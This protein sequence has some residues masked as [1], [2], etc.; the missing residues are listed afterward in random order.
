MK[1]VMKL[2]GLDSQEDYI[3]LCRFSRVPRR[4]VSKVSELHISERMRGEGPPA[5]AWSGGRSG[6]Y[7]R[8]RALF[9]V[10][11]SMLHK[12]EILM[13]DRIETKWQAEASGYSITKG[14]T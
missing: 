7:Y 14:A 6:S 13:A 11:S 10:K 8:T 5:D 1:I 12:L 3:W 9:Y 4:P 2:E